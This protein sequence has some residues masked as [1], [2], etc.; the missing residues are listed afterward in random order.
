MNGTWVQNLL[1]EAI[2]APNCAMCGLPFM[3]EFT[4]EFTM[5]F[6]K[7]FNNSSIAFVKSW[8]EMR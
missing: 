4:K 6:T 2:V 3:K 8:C 7:D 1:L 5:D